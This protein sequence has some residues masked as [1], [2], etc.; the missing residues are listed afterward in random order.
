MA[1]VKGSGRVGLEGPRLP[2]CSAQQHP[3]P[4]ALQAP[5]SNSGLK[6]SGLELA[7]LNCLPL[8]ESRS[9]GLET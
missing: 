7:T 4:Q 8:N 1:L 9:S 2:F 6:G 3:Q 5:T